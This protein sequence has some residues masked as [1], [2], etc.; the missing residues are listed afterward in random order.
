MQED[1]AVLLFCNY[2]QI[3]IYAI[4]KIVMYGV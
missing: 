1:R 4:G 2:N 3:D